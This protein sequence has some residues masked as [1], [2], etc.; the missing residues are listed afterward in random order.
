MKKLALLLIVASL[1]ISGCAT[2]IKGKTQQVN[3]GTSNNEPITATI[4]GQSV[5]VPG[6]VTVN[7]TKENLTI[8]T[9]AENC[10]S[11][12]V[13]NSSVEPTFWVNILSGGAFG[14][15]TD[16]GSE[17]MWKYDDQITINC[18]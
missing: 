17:S 15:T 6:V 14:S 10:T 12:Q 2:I 4:Q 3:I 18:K 1:S 5:K 11:T 16:Y 13:A 7:R 9:E 8:T